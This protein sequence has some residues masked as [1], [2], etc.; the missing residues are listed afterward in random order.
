M[1]V[2]AIQ[3]TENFTFRKHR[4]KVENPNDVETKHQA[5][6]RCDEFAFLESGDGTANPR[7]ERN[8]SKDKA[9][10]TVK[11]KVIFLCHDKLPPNFVVFIIL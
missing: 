4:N 1:F 2:L 9:D 7:R 5:N 10:K 8:D 3:K 11:T 6:N